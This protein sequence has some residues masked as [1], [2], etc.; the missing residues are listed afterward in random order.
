M[1][2]K[3]KNITNFDIKLE[4]NTLTKSVGNDKIHKV[5]KYCSDAIEE[6]CFFEN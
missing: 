4:K 1:Y 3:P 2:K 5:K 6:R